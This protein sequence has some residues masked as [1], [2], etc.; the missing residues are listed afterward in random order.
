MEER[1]ANIWDLADDHAIVIP[2]N[3]GW[4]KLGE[5]TM[6]RGLA[7]QAAKKFP[8]LPKVLGERYKYIHSRRSRTDEPGVNDK[9]P[10]LIVRPDSRHELVFLPTKKLISP[11]YLSWKQ[12]SDLHLIAKGLHYL[13]DNTM[14][15][16]K[17]PR[18]AIPLVGAG[19]GKLDKKAVEATIKNILGDLDNVT[20]VIFPEKLFNNNHGD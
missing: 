13:K 15:Q 5:N 16:L 2:T 11:A 9:P 17:K 8:N 7:K 20:L 3:I 18:V 14:A 6:G 19:N 4:T 1:K 10:V 12:P